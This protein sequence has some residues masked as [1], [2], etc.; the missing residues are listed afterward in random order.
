[1]LPGESVVVLTAGTTTDPYSDEALPDWSTPV[2]VTVRDV[3]VE[4]LPPEPLDDIRDA[5][6]SRLTLYFQSVP[7]VPLARARVQVRG[8]T[9]DVQGEPADWRLGA[10]QPG[11]AVSVVDLLTARRAA[12]EALMVDTCM[13][14]GQ[15]GTT[16][17]DNGSET[18]TY[19]TVY[20]GK[21]RVQIQAASSSTAAREVG[22]QQ[23]SLLA[24]VV[25]VPVVG[26]EGIHVRDRVTL[27]RA[28][29]DADLE[30]RVFWVS[31]PAPSS[32]A[33]ARLLSC[34][35]VTA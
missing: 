10:W 13:I 2:S 5:V 6:T 35:E 25:Q 17:Y 7:S 20:T 21:C 3:L 29:Y 14:D 8:V 30:G 15:T 11:L 31:Q 27:L 9:Y 16:L 23:V 4:R 19:T 22:D 12:A 32:D 26:T 24:I 34:V 33:S 18:P 28:T 1:M